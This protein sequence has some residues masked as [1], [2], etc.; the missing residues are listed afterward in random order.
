MNKTKGTWG[1]LRPGAGQ[2][3]KSDNEKSVT[4]SLSLRPEIYYPLKRESE[5]RGISLNDLIREKIFPKK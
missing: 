3:R 2:K 1:G 5:K 4:V